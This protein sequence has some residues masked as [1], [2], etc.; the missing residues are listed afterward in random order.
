MQVRIVYVFSNSEE[1]LCEEK[2]VEDENNIKSFILNKKQTEIVE[3]GVKLR[4]LPKVIKR[5]LIQQNAFID[6]RVPT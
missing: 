1:H 6:G 2:I 4:A 5:D 3:V